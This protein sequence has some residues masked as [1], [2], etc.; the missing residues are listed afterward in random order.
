MWAWCQRGCELLPSPV[1][2]LNFQQFE[3][4]GRK[5]PAIA[6]EFISLLQAYVVDWAERVG[7]VE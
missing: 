7:A 2:R 3:H 5:L 1:V 6:E 4:S